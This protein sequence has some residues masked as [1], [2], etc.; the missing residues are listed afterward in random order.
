MEQLSSDDEP[1]RRGLVKPRG[2]Q[3]FERDDVIREPACGLH[4]GQQPCGAAR[5]GRTHG[6]TRPRS[7]MPKSSCA[8][9]VVH[10]WTPSL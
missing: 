5:T 10:T 4:Q 8:A 9:E 2:S 6:C 1:V 3:S 7:S